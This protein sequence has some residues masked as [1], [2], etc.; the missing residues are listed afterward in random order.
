MTERRY[1][2]DSP[3]E[4]NIWRVYA[5][6]TTHCNRACPWCSTCSS[7]TGQSWLTLE[8]LRL[9][10]PASGAYELQLEGGE[11]LLHPHFA[12]FVE[13]ARSDSRCTRIIICTNGTTLPRQKERLREL[14]IRLGSPLT[15]KLSLNHH[16]LENDLG[17]PQL[18][19]HLLDL[20]EAENSFETVINIRLRRGVADDDAAVLDT[21]RRYRLLQHANVFYLQRYGFAAD[22][23]QWEA[24]HLVSNRFSMINPDGQV[25]SDLLARSE[26]MRLLP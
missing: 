1:P 6:L 3:L 5:A 7:P 21:A 2:L 12:D 11:P 19:R 20:A 23:T 8:S 18:A 9:T 24:P 17:L 26:A 25:F 4:R 15:I 14:L 13:F 22:Q 10:L 16:L